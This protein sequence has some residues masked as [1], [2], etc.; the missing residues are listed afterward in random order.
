M[1]YQVTLQETHEIVIEVE[2]GSESEAFTDALKGRG[3][4]VR[5]KYLSTNTDPDSA[6]ITPLQGSYTSLE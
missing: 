6:S 4:E 3:R 1:K 5:M 2:A